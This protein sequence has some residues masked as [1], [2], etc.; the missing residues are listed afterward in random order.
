MRAG[1]GRWGRRLVVAAVLVVLGAGALL[2]EAV[3]EGIPRVIASLLTLAAFG[4]GAASV[5]VITVRWRTSVRF[6]GES[7]VVRD[8]LG[9]RVV[10]VTDR[11]ILGRG[12]DSA[13]TPTYW[14]FDGERRAVPISPDLDPVR[15]EG[16]AYSLGIPIVD[17]DDAPGFRRL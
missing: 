15:L 10:P 8:P 14:L 17:I 16:L 13:L 4:L 1:V 2:A 9:A 5:A 11:D 7:L 3:P 12:L 6:D